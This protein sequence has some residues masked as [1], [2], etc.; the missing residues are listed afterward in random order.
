MFGIGES[1]RGKVVADV[2][3]GAS[4]FSAEWHRRHWGRAIAIDPNYGLSA[5]Q[6]ERRVLDGVAIASNNVKVSPQD[7]RWNSIFESAA[8]HLR[9]RMA[10]AER[11]LTDVRR[12][13]HY[14]AASVEFL[15]LRSESVDLVISS[16]LLFTYAGALSLEF[17]ILAI[18]EM[19]RVTRS[20]VRIFPIV[21]FDCDASPILEGVRQW[22]QKE[23]GVS[24]DAVAVDYEFLRGADRMLR[25]KKDRLRPPLPRSSDSREVQELA[26]FG[27]VH[28]AYHGAW[29]WDNVSAILRSH[30]H[31]VAC[32]DLPS[33]DPAAGAYEYASAALDD[34]RALDNDLIVVGHS[35]A[36]LIIPLVAVRRSVRAMVFLSAMLPHIGSAQRDVLATERDMLFPSPAGSTWSVAEVSYYRSEHAVKRFF[37]DCP[38]SVAVAAAARLRGQCWKI[39]DEQCPLEEWPAVPS[40]YILGTRDQV[41]N[42]NWARRVVPSILGAAPIELPVGHSAFLAAPELLAQALCAVVQENR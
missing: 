22:C 15:P 39:L 21:G 1:D 6:L 9:E 31:V 35:L 33:E 17:H 41:V 29:C 4:S 27:L 18:S 13:K 42:P 5:E 30:G 38:E 40:Y 14:L 3:A 28:G 34:F 2:G 20:E 24:A 26:S 16:H 25:I 7:Y 8:D 36:G 10:T 19:I 11:F 37:G 12:N 32:T 23:V